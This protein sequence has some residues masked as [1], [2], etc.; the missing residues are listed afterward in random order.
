M[1][2]VERRDGRRCGVEADTT[3]AGEIATQGR[4]LHAARRSGVVIAP[5]R[6]LRTKALTRTTPI[7]ACGARP[8]AASP[9]MA[10]ASG[11][12]AGG[13]SKRARPPAGRA[14]CAARACSL[15]ALGARAVIAKTKA[16]LDFQRAFLSTCG[17]HSRCCSYT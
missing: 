16:F 13:A 2:R 17:F 10:A 6:G 1:G 4:G 8:D 3:A 9:T 15:T 12:T 11:G 14:P 5:K 7:A